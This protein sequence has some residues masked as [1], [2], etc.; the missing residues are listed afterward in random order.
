MPQEPDSVSPDACGEY[1]F[2]CPKI[3]DIAKVQN[4]K[5]DLQH[6][7]EQG[8]DII[9]LRAAQV[10]RIDAA[11]LQLLCAFIRQTT[12]HTIKIR[13]ESPS[14]A[15]CR[16]AELLGLSDHLLLLPSNQDPNPEAAKP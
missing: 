9:V 14:A 8:S 7:L 2:E 11:G 3:F 5:E 12:T 4:I 1:S 16:A 10:E 15:L 13:W 6:I